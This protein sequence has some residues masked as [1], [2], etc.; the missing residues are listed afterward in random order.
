MT[1]NEFLRALEHE[2]CVP[3]GSLNE[4]QELA[5]LEIWDSMAA[6]Q[7]IAL[8]DEAVG[9]AIPENQIARSKTVGELLSLLEPGLVPEQRHRVAGESP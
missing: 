6:V 2:L 9:I 5:S 7:F 4:Q 3:E 8:A 1:K